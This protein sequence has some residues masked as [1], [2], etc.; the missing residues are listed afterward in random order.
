MQRFSRTSTSCKRTLMP[1]ES[2]ARSFEQLI[3]DIKL[4]FSKLLT[5]NSQGNPRSIRKCRSRS[6]IRGWSSRKWCISTK[7]SWNSTLPS[8]LR[9][10]SAKP[11]SLSRTPAVNS[12]RQAT[13][14]RLTRVHVSIESMC[15]ASTWSKTRRCKSRRWISSM[16]LIHLSW[17]ENTRRRLTS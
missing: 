15:I 7:R 8:K 5:V 2:A 9:P 13:K 4:T 10:R 3:I 14:R 16:R 12:W 11:S 6:K 1:S 17:K